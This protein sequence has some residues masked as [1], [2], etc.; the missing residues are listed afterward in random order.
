MWTDTD[1]KK[2]KKKIIFAQVS[3]DVHYILLKEAHLFWWR[4]RIKIEPTPEIGL[5]RL[6][7]IV[8]SVNKTSHSASK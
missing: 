5:S 4:I 3:I 2:I 6:H 7:L 1:I 8:L